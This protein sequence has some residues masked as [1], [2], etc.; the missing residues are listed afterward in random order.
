MDMDSDRRKPVALIQP[1]SVLR[2][3]GLRIALFRF[4]GAPAG[5]RLA[6]K[7]GRAKHKRR[8]MQLHVTSGYAFLFTFGDGNET[9]DLWR[10][11]RTCVR[12][13]SCGQRK[14]VCNHFAITLKLHCLLRHLNL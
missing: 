5:I 13:T 14:D 6:R 2:K 1:G 3:G 12:R 7:R 11:V 9:S 4:D 8:L 10:R